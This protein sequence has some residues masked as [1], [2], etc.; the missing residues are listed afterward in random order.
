MNR[1]EIM[2][3]LFEEK[4]KYATA[5]DSVEKAIREYDDTINLIMSNMGGIAGE[6]AENDE[7]SKRDMEMIASFREHVADALRDVNS[8][9]C[10]LRD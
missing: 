9:K 7:I 6:A 10:L 4:S 5:I 1:T 8:L 3:M 2:K